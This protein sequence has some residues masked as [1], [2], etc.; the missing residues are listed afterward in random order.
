MPPTFARIRRD[1]GRLL[2]GDGS[3][4][5]A[6][7][8]GEAGQLREVLVVPLTVRSHTADDA[9]IR[10]LI[11][12]TVS[13]AHG[14]RIDRAELERIALGVVVPAA[15][16]WVRRHPLS[17]LQTEID[18]N[19]TLPAVEETARDQVAAL[20]GDLV[21]LTLVAGEHLLLS[22]SAEVIDGAR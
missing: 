15:A 11:E 4:A 5:T 10:L 1:L 21:A 22:P 6:A 3:L 7:V 13:H 19:P 14:G 2:A 9:E 8:P 18:A 16:A 17:E 20:G 12:A